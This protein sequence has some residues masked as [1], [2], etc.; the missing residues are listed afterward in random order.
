M[1]LLNNTGDMN[2]IYNHNQG[3]PANRAM[4]VTIMWANLQKLQALYKLYT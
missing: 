1:I 4:T 3:R 2:T